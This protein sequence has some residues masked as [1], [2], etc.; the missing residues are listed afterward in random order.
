MNS[1]QES[2]VAQSLEENQRM[3][4][5]FAKILEGLPCRVLV[6]D[7][8]MNLRMMNP[9]AGRLLNG[10]REESLAGNA[11]PRL[12][13]PLLA[14]LP[15]EDFSHEQE[16]V[17]EGGRTLGVTR[18]CFQATESGE[19]SLLILRDLTEA[20][21]LER[22][23][24]ISRRSQALAEVLPCSP[25]DSEPPR[26]PGALSP[27]CSRMLWQI[28]QSCNPGSITSRPACKPSPRR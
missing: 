27:G 20:K 17:V 16:W 5:Y 8:R 21:K 4:T 9:A 26:E 25:M 14:A 23:R 2:Q 3:R 28:R 11:I 19:D 13:G 1:E 24:E 15:R 7:G 10:D 6:F 22:E 12:M 18:A